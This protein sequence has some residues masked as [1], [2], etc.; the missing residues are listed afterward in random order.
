MFWRHCETINFYFR[1]ACENLPDNKDDAAAENGAVLF[2]CCGFGIPHRLQS[3]E[4]R[5]CFR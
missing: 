3:L 4:S 2:N 1:E 5:P